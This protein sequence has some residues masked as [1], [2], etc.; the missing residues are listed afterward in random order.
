MGGAGSDITAE[1]ALDLRQRSIR[2]EQR[3]SS[4]TSKRERGCPLAQDHSVE[5]KKKKKKKK[6]KNK[7]KKKKK[8]GKKKTTQTP[9]HPQKKKTNP[10][11]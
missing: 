2:E 8:K 3:A 4:F 6:K 11:T 10:N 7:K 1:R 5:K 9:K